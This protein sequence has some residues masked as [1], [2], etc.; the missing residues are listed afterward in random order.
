MA[1]R[2]VIFD[3]GD[4]LWPLRY[5]TAIWPRVRELLVEDF[6]RL[7]AETP[8][9]A[10]ETVDGL[11]REV[12][13][14]LAD[15][16][17]G[18][19]Y[20]QLSFHHYVERAL[21]QVGLEGEELVEAVCQAFF[22][23]EHRHAD[24]QVD[25]ETI[26]LLK[27]LQTSGLRIGMVSNT[28]APGHFHQLALHR[29]DAARWIDVPVYSTDLGCRKPDRRIYNH[30]LQLLGVEAAEALF[31]GDRL[32]EDVMGPQQLGMRAALYRRYR[33]EEP[34]EEIQPDFVVD[35]PPE[36]LDV[37]RKLEGSA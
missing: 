35:S 6:C 27:S 19:S 22:M 21:G 13:R 1:L 14:I 16:F 17:L 37:V 34:S 36:V 23:A 31:V 32:R 9:Q 5:E 15:T 8:E 26:E 4:T 20:D 11:R 28:F 33:R 7:R 10:G 3:L 12:G 18:E 24:V 25:G 2:A 29:C 30:C